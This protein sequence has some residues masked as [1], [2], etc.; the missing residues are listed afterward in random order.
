MAPSDEDLV[1]SFQEGDQS[2]FETIFL[3]YRGRIYGYLIRLIRDQAVAEEMFQEVFLHLFRRAS[4][5]DS[6]R[7][8]R[9]WF[10]RVAHN[11]TMDFFRKN[12]ERE[13]LEQLE[14]LLESPPSPEELAL[15]AE[16]ARDLDQMLQLLSEEHR[17][18]LLLRF[19]EDLTYEEVAE[20]FDCPVGTA[21]SRTHHAIKNLRE[22][23]EKV[24][25]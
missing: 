6:T 17:S 25:G 14:D 2:A 4:Q 12:Q 22:L 5:F 24:K 9:S 20:V 8:F 19:K 13:N 21:K 11:R 10:F 1:K 23:M 16:T 18:V 7:T 15:K 3:R